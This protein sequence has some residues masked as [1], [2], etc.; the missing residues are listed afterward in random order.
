MAYKFVTLKDSDGNTLYPKTGINLGTPIVT[1]RNNNLMIVLSSKSGLTA[2]D[3]GLSVSLSTKGLENI[4]DANSG[5]SGI[6][7]DKFGS[8][9]VKLE[10]NDTIYLSTQGYLKIDPS[11]LP[12]VKLGTG[13][14]FDHNGVLQIKL[15][16]GL[17]FNERDGAIQI[18]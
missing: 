1:D 10:D 5:S 15:G 12:K 9:A 16:S 4:N 2:D 7:I 3:K 18:E 14:Y 8:L 6:E 11:R 17:E 13:L